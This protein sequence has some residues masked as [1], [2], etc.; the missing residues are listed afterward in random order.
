MSIQVPSKYYAAR[1]KTR[2]ENEIPN[3]SNTLH[4]Q[5]MSLF[6]DKKMIDQT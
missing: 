2:K 4:F 3:F 5:T 6:C 1:D